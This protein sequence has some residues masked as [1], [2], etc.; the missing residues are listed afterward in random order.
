M[1]F[2]SYIFVF[3]FLPLSLAGYYAAGRK[4]GKKAAQV[5]LAA[6][7]L[8]FYGSFSFGCLAVL[9]GSVLF[10]YMICLKMNGTGSSAIDSAWSGNWN[11]AGRKAGK[12]LLVTGIAGNLILLAFFKYM[13]FFIGNLNAVS[14][15]DL[16]FLKLLLPV[17]ISFFTFQQISW[18]VDNYRGEIRDC[19]FLE[20]LLY[21]TYF[22][23]LAE[24]PIVRHE[25]LL[26]QFAQ[27]GEKRFDGEGFARGICLFIFGMFKKV[28]LADTFGGAVD[29][30]YGNL[31]FMHGWDALLLVVFYSLQLYFDFSGYCDMGR[32]ISRMFGIEL[33]VNFNSPYKGK[34][35]IDFWKR[36]HIT[37]NRFFTKYVYIP[38]GGNREGRG[39]MYRNLLLVFLLSGLWHG[40]GWNFILWGMMHGVLYVFTRMWQQ[41]KGYRPAG[42]AS[43]MIGMLLTFLYVSVAWVYFRA[44]GIAQGN[45]LLGLIFSHDFVRV[46]KNLAGYFNLDEFWYLIKLLRL[47]RW[48]FGHYILMAAMTL[49]SL[50]L[51]FFGKNAVQAA[52]KI[53]LNVWN[54]VW[55]A[56]LFLWCVLTISNVST[57]LYFN[58]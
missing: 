39:K 54:A 32:G 49:V 31:E 20:Y 51:V 56:G 41:R 7:S 18:L 15:K 11:G 3:L 21:I 5:W 13:N 35:I 37:L 30:G 2:N 6:M 48:E 50:I 53:K 14:G 4:L 1:L 25:E 36:W 34:N 45:Q 28:I 43:G 40:A 55:M 29:Y 58:F 8:W 42:K 17:G 9:A 44:D 46:N 22:P 52:E 26:P 24:G 47:D 19:G 10:N 33:P 12:V 23:K 16:P 38:L 57:F 27:A